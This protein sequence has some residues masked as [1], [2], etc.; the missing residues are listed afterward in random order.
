MKLH[1]IPH[2][3]G[4]YHG[5]SK[6]HAQ[7]GDSVEKVDGHRDPSGSGVST[8]NIGCF[9]TSHTILSRKKFYYYE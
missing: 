6:P 3:E 1:Y 5:L 7:N 9:K 4:E 8:Q 2:Q